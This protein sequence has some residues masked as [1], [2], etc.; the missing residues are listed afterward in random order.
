MKRSKPSEIVFVRTDAGQLVYDIFFSKMSAAT[1]VEKWR[2]KGTL[3][4]R[5]VYRWR[6]DP[7]RKQALC[8]HN[9]GYELRLTARERGPKHP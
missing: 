4:L 7:L 5:Q 1:V 3:T 9:S 6:K 2:S 8:L